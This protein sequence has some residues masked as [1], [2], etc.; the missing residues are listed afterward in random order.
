MKKD[1]TYKILFVEDV[2]TD[3]QLAERYLKS[4]GLIFTSQTVETEKNY[5]LTI[6]EFKPDIIISDYSLPSFNGMEAIKLATIY[7]PGTP[8]IIFTGSIDE[9][10]AVKCMKAGACDYVL[11]EKLLRLPF[12]VK[13]ALTLKE[14]IAEK[15]LAV[16]A[17]NESEEKF[18]YL[19]DSSPS[20]IFV[21]NNNKYVFSNPA[22]LDLLGYNSLED[23]YGVNITDTVDEI[24][25]GL[26]QSRLVDIS[27]NIPNK[28][29]D[30]KIKQKNGSVVWTESMSIP[31][32]YE[33]KNS[34]LVMCV[35]I[36]D[37]ILAQEKLAESERELELQNEINRIFL[38]HSDSKMYNLIL[39]ILLREFDC[40]FGLFG[41]INE[42]GELVLSS[43]T[44][45]I[46]EMC[47]IPRKTYVFP[48]DKWGGLWG[49]CLIEKK[50]F[51]SNQNLIVPEG[52]IHLNNALCVPLVYKNQL[53]GIFTI[54]NKSLEFNLSDQKRLEL[55]ASNVS[56]ILSARLERDF[57]EEKRKLTQDV[58]YYTEERLRLAL[59]ATSDG[60]W[61]WDCITDS[62]YWSP[63]TFIMLGYE[64]D[65]FNV[66]IKNYLDLIHPSDK[67]MVWTSIQTQ[68]NGVEKKFSVE[69][70]I[71]KKSGEYLWVL[72]RGKVVEFD[73]N[74][75]IKRVV[76]THVDLTKIKKDEMK[77]KFQSDILNQIKDL[78]VATDLDGNIIFV[79]QA[80]CDTFG[81]SQNEL[82]KSHVNIFGEDEVSGAKQHE[83]LDQTKKIGYWNGEVV[84]FDKNGNKIVLHCR[85]WLINDE[86][87]MPYA[88]VGISTDITK[89]K[90]AVDLLRLSEENYRLLTETA[91]D[92]IFM[93]NVN[94]EITY[95]NKAGKNLIGWDEGKNN[96]NVMD[97]VPETYL[98]IILQNKKERD[99]GDFNTRI[100]QIE[101]F[102]KNKNLIPVEVSSCPIIINKQLTGVL[103]IARDI[104]ERI[105]NAKKIKESEEKFYKAFHAN[106]GCMAI[107][108]VKGKYFEVNDSF[109]ELVGYEKIEIVGKL[110]SELKIFINQNVFKFI[111]S[112]ENSVAK[113][114]DV[115]LTLKTKNGMLKQT[116]LSADS[117]V[118]FDQMCHL[119]V[120]RDIT[121]RKETEMA[122]VKSENLFRSV[123]ENSKDGMRLTEEHG[124]IVKVNN[125]FCVLMGKSR[126]E[127]EGQ[128]IS[129][130]YSN[131]DSTRVLDSYSRNFSTRKINPYFESKYVLWDGKI[132]WLAVS[133]SL[134]SSDTQKPLV[135]SL[136]RDIT[137]R[138][139]SEEDLIKAKI[140]AE[141]SNRLKDAFIANIS[142]EI[143][144]P[145]NGIL[146]MT[147]LIKDSLDNEISKDQNEYFASIQR[148][149]NR[150][151]RTMEMIVN[152]SRLQVGEFPVSPKSIN[153]CSI[154]NKLLLEYKHAA[155]NKGL[156]LIFDCSVSDSFITAD[157]YSITNAI[158]YLL[159]N[160]IKFTNKGEVKISLYLE[161]NRSVVCIEDRGIGI[162]E[163]YS[164]RLFEPYSQEEIGYSRSHEG[165]GLGLSLVKKFLALN[166][167]TIS[168]KTEK[169][170]GTSFKIN[171]STD[172]IV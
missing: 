101:I 7:S 88:L 119:I 144:T 58:L 94:G 40:K 61:D 115:E 108:S 102:D 3:V 13:E 43:M 24:S 32:I 2:K 155:L 133:S 44:S 29:V 162:S 151:I 34:V 163:D 26:I 73:L 120:I 9:E 86:D 64:P 42:N 54:A 66:T 5:L 17:L 92:I 36:N 8:I 89:Q 23:L 132:V 140:E 20:S 147:S 156:Y 91:T 65:E 22:G 27:N 122:L 145:L 166:K 154:I 1:Y 103:V 171:F 105:K 164:R 97:Y 165:V 63:R 31:I 53:I 70:R 113:I 127:L 169:G 11:K 72:S 49:K 138:K 59:H 129:T 77:L 46:W 33:G 149:S 21:L 95:L 52:H 75:K 19:I 135:L 143:R 57:N 45:D 168:V 69:F 39:D 83:I 79:N 121:K 84:N 112:A 12:A 170:V 85:T 114:R 137:D 128:L 150:I 71:A 76:G 142:H 125:A 130:L 51:F 56:P 68:I 159:D 80:E 99:A 109:A 78:V 131:I 62:I 152:Y 48:Q 37:K 10:T 60:L 153:L 172:S 55:I 117:F 6:K 124:V 161:N 41:Y 158:S 4:E 82:L 87:K 148:S 96:N 81:V 47:K 116:L 104:T 67:D 25:V 139:K 28:I 15:K 167:A 90:E 35:D 141:K 160:A 123:W 107:T 14:E 110:E 38:S 98:P 146:G 136:F 16:K 126:N 111:S 74:K 157:E 30:I 93:H 50:S 100:Y 134:L 106:A 118:L 18:K